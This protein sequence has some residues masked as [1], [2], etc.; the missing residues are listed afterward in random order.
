VCVKVAI[1]SDSHDHIW[2]VRRA[3]AAL[4]ECAALLFCGDLCSPFVIPLLAE[5]FAERPIHIVF[6]NNDGDLYRI[7]QNAAK[8]DHVQLHGEL[9]ADELGG[10]RIGANHYP[11]LAQGLAD[12]GR[13]DLV[14]YGH[15]H[16]LA[17]E[18]RGKTVVVNPGTLLGY[19][20]VA[21]ADVPA[22]FMVYDLAADEAKAFQVASGTAR[23]LEL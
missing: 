22:S 15:D 5:G 10:R 21:R 23:P 20:P 8:H 6:G 1:L 14:F 3:L 2:N 17:L 16:R 13:F 19:D 11:E 9:F 4:D 18:R 12:S 7:S